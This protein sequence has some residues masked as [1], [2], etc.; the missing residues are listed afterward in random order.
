MY[1]PIRMLK[2]R[3]SRSNVKVLKNHYQDIKVKDRISIQEYLIYN[4]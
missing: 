4:F 3:I 1:D 2:Y